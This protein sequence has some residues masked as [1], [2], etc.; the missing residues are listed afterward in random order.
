MKKK[1]RPALTELNN[2]DFLKTKTDYC[3]ECKRKTKQEIYRGHTFAEGNKIVFCL[4][5]KLKILV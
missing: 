5:C 3:E 1:Y 2:Y 4:K